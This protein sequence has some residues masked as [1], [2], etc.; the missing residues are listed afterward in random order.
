M[1]TTPKRKFASARP[2]LDVKKAIQT[3]KTNKDILK[4]F[5]AVRQLAIDDKVALPS[6]KKKK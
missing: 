4:G 6:L 3:V 5:M 1:P 2:K